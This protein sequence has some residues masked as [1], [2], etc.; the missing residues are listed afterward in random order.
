MDYY[1]IYFV[2]YLS[3]LILDKIID[4]ESCS[5]N[6]RNVFKKHNVSYQNK[7]IFNINFYYDIE[8]NLEFCNLTENNN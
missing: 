3:N 1:L 2:L 8:M 5:Y 7:A 6:I 4:S